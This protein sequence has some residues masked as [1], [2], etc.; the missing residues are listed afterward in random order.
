MVNKLK[1][2]LVAMILGLGLVWSSEVSAATHT[3]SRGET[4]YSIS[5][6]HGVSVYS[7]AQSNGLSLG[8]TILP[9]QT[10]NIPGSTSSSAEP[11]NTSS[12]S[13]LDLLYAVVMQESGV[14]SVGNRAVTSTILNR[15]NSGLF[16]NTITEVLYQPGQFAS[17]TGDGL[18]RQY[19]GG[20]A[21][22]SVKDNVNAVMAGGSEHSYLY[23]W[24]DWYFH[25]HSTGQ[26]GVNLGGNVFFN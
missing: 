7:L 15:V 12:S 23:F 26:Q 1:V 5:R 8:T 24:A 25:Q 22:Q 10:I 14:S 6:Q 9:N 16:P 21:P 19:M 13:E 11:G 4:L 3:V 20:K 2:F 17:L 18:A